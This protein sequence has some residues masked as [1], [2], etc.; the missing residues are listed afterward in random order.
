MFSIELS[1]YATNFLKFVNPQIAV[2][3][4]GENNR[5]G[6]PDLETIEILENQE[7]IEHIFRTDM[8]G[9]IILITDGS[10]YAMKSFDTNEIIHYILN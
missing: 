3:S 5:Y 6:H 10:Q 1:I 4:A 8:D 2:I 9:T 7:S